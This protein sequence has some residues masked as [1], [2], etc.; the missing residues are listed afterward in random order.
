[1]GLRALFVSPLSC[2]LLS[3]GLASLSFSA[4]KTASVMPVL[5]E[6][7]GCGPSLSRVLGAPLTSGRRGPRAL[8]GWCGSCAS[9]A[10]GSG[11]WHGWCAAGVS[12][13][14]GSRTCPSTTLGTLSPSSLH[15]TAAGESCA[16]NLLP[17]S[18]F[19]AMVSGQ[20]ACRTF[21][22]I[23]MMWTRALPTKPDGFRMIAFPRMK[24]SIMSPRSWA[25]AMNLR[26]WRMPGTAASRR[27][28]TIYMLVSGLLA[29]LSSISVSFANTRSIPSSVSALFVNLIS[30]R[31]TE[32]ASKNLT[33]ING[34]S[35]T[36]GNSSGGQWG[37]LSLRVYS[38]LPSE[39]RQSPIGGVL[40]AS[41]P[42]CG[43]T[44]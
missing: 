30:S 20:A 25:N 41:V 22:S 16:R 38:H 33:V 17:S 12:L 13:T 8:S 44:P 7:R 35:T 11:T 9:L 23:L 18:S 3:T 15:A 28:H 34:S 4:S 27:S 5:V 29:R 24:R 42:L 43:V 32:L 26:T 21:C 37:K 6:E 40:S 31:D 1:M 10:S 14:S 19:G 2:V 39:L 36:N